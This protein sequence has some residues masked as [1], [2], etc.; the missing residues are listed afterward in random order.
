MGILGV[1]AAS[2]NTFGRENILSSHQW[3]IWFISLRAK[4]CGNRTQEGGVM[5][6]WGKNLEMRTVCKG[7]PQRDFLL[8][9]AFY[10]GLDIPALRSPSG[11]VTSSLPHLFTVLQAAPL[12]C[13]LK[14]LRTP[15]HW[16]A[17]LSLVCPLSV[18]LARLLSAPFRNVDKALFAAD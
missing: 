3:G 5:L 11:A 8:T 17:S 7:V 15:I 1:F 6:K 2:V 16:E 12:S 9:S 13:Y 10:Q 4:P 14:H 18:L